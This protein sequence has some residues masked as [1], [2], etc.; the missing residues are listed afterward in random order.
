MRPFALA[1]VEPLPR[2]PVLFV[3][4]ASRFC[5]H[6]RLRL[7]VLNLLHTD[8]PLICTSY[9]DQN[10][11]TPTPQ[12]SNA[13]TLQRPNTPTPQ[14]YSA[15]LAR[16][17]NRCSAHAYHNTHNTYRSLPD[18][19][20]TLLYTITKTKSIIRRHPATRVSNIGATP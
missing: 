3:Y 20:N 1:L 15:F 17:H 19:R 9:N 10:S 13:P 18:P 4:R 2:L 8:Y 7:V 12:H 16:S 14:Q 5:F 6:L 11:N